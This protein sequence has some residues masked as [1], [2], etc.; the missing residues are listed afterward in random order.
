MA[1]LESCESRALEFREAA[2][3]GEGHDADHERLIAE[4]ADAFDARADEIVLAL[5]GC[6]R[7]LSSRD[8]VGAI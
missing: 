7:A 5:T 8:A 3:E 2:A 1:E 6:R 4:E